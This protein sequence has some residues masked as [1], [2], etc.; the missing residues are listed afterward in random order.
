MPWRLCKGPAPLH[1]V[2]LCYSTPEMGRVS[3]VTSFLDPPGDTRVPA[4]L[5]C[6]PVSKVDMSR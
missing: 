4:M 3:Q 1:S 2:G 6:P 5:R